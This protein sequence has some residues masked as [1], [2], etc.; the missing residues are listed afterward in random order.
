MATRN[1]NRIGAVKRAIENHIHPKNGRS[2]LISSYSNWY[3]G[4]SNNPL[5]RKA[6]HEY[7]KQLTA[8]H[9]QYWELDC[10]ED[11]LEVEEYFHDLGMADKKGAGGVRRNTTT[12]YVFKISP[13]LFELIIDALS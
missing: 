3:I 2:F 13:H 9:F 7:T 10:K 1:G 12:V 5:V 6:Q 11:A 4:V 8:M